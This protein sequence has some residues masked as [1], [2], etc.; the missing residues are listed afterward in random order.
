MKLFQELLVTANVGRVKLDNTL[1]G[2]N[3]TRYIAGI[4]L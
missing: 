1:D 2:D 4:Q 3:S